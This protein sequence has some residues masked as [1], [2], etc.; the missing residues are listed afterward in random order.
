MGGEMIDQEYP[1]NDKEQI[2]TA[3]SIWGISVEDFYYVENASGTSYVNIE[4][5]LYELVSVCG[6][7][8]LFSNERLTED[9]IPNGLFLYHLRNGSNGEQLCAIESNVTVDCSGSIVT[10]EPLDL[11]DKGFLIFDDNHTLNFMSEN[12]T[13]GQFLNGD[14]ET[15]ET[16]SFG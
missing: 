6:Q 7:P 12:I 9:D 4:S 14:F 11:G 5:D 8:G 16:I 2:E 10:G 3:A 13:F 15:K 1:Q